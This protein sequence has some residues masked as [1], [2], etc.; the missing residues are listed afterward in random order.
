MTACREWN[1]R[2][3]DYALGSAAAEVEAHVK[4]CSACAAAL[5]E[6]CA[7][8]RQL[9]SA[10]STWVAGA[11]P[12]PAFRARVLAAAESSPARGLA[13]P[14]WAGAFAAVAVVILVGALVPRFT[15]PGTDPVRSGASLSNWRSPT[16]SL[17]RPPAQ[18][19]FLSAP[20]LG[21]FYF[22]LKPAPAGADSKTGGKNES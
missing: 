7:A 6:L 19:S 22:P 12:S 5:A 21:E 3:L 20:R 9:D 1:D 2:L 11:A 15:P 16:E 13:P 10:L 8:N 4:A 14:A 18:D 17:L